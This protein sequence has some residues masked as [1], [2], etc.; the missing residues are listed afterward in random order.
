MEQII[1]QVKD[2]EKAKVLLDLLAVL[3]FV[4]SVKTGATEEGEGETT[5]REEAADCFV[6]KYHVNR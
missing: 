6:V 4:D 1:I 2:K 5:V 3:D